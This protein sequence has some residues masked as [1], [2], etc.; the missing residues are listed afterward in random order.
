MPGVHACA[1]VRGKRPARATR[2]ARWRRPRLR[3]RDS[4][5]H[6]P[7]LDPDPLALTANRLPEI[8]ELVLHDVVDRIARRVHVLAHLLDD[9]VDRNAIDQILATLDRRSEPALRARR[10]QRAP[11][12]AGHLPTERLEPR[13]P[14]HFAPSRPAS[15]GE[16]SAHARVPHQRPDRTAPR[17]PAPQQQRDSR[18]DRRPDE[19]RGQQVVLLLTLL[20]QTPFLGRTRGR[21]FSQ[22]SAPPSS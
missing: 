4:A 8:V 19:R 9:I 17:R 5:R 1:T 14:A 21:G 10:A 15:P 12:A 22:S 16:R 6:S 18:A 20:V 11:S 7:R 2:P 13:P 3:A